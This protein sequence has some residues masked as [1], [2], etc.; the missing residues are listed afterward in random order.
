[1]KL[2]K[3]R[4][5][6]QKFSDLPAIDVS[7]SMDREWESL[8][9]ELNL[10]PGAKIAIAVGSRGIA[11]LEEIVR[12]VVDKLRASGCDSLYRPGNGISWRR[13]S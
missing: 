8:K 4:M 6:D 5:V 13:H 2:P 3:M 12:I 11:N 7:S 1:M 10:Q 9:G